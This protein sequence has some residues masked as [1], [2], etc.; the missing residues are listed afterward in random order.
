MNPRLNRFSPLGAALLLV[1]SLLATTVSAHAPTRWLRQPGVTCPGAVRASGGNSSALL[2][3]EKTFSFNLFHVLYTN[4]NQNVFLSP[5]SIAVALDMLY[6]G[7]RGPTRRAMARTLGLDTLTPA[8]VRADTAAWISSLSQANSGSRL[9]IANSIWAR[10]GIAFRQAFLQHMSTS[11]GAKISTLNFRSPSA[12]AAI[13]G[14]V[15]CATHG[16][17]PS[18]ISAVDPMTLMYLLNAVYFRGGWAD[19]F[20]PS[21]TQPHT[22][23]TALGGMVRVPMMH[24]SVRT[25]YLAG[26]DFQLVDLPYRGAFS[27][28]I[29]LPRRGESLRT[30]SGRFTEKNWA[31]WTSQL[32]RHAG[33]IALPRFG[34]SYGT[35]LNHALSLLGMASIFKPSADFSG[36]CTTAC[37]VSS[38]LHKTYLRVDEKGTVAAA[39]TAVGIATSSTP[40]QGAPFHMVVDH[41]FFL[42]IR[43]DRSGALLFLGAVSNPI[44][45]R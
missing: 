37:R 36:I 15:K 18:I 28:A 30:F 2:A 21:A 4:P 35:S 24:E 29:L 31:S 23:T 5:L 26:P 8:A 20:A 10:Q 42:A 38:V 1:L 13:N 9:E 41:P 25:G 32:R 43:D 11:Y 39:V 12:V 16:T 14:W 27:M 19:P 33:T 40:Q 6:D 17:I 34:F 22:F 7:A 45:V 3:G 44:P